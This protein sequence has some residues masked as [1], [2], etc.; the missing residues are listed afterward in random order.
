MDI[1]NTDTE[2]ERERDTAR[3]RRELNTHPRWM[4]SR[5]GA[6]LCEGLGLAVMVV[7]AA[8]VVA[9]SAAAVAAVDLLVFLLHMQLVRILGSI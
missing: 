6:R 2:R 7:A 1:A 4:G 8:A 5:A 9:A 3:D